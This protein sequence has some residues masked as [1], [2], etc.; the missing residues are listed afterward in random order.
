MIFKLLINRVK[1]LTKV[2]NIL[3]SINKIFLNLF[4]AYIRF[5]SQ[6][7]YE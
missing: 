1:I 3:L 2:K 6:S 7:E 4:T 5:N